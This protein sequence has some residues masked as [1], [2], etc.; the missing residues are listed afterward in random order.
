MDGGDLEE[1]AAEFEDCATSP[2]ERCG[3]ALDEVIVRVLQG[4][5]CPTAPPLETRERQLKCE[6]NAVRPKSE[7]TDRLREGLS[8]K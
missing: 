4:A 7:K 5:E 6:L 2:A 8:G 3:G 1:L